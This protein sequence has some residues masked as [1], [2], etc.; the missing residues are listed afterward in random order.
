MAP[1][2]AVRVGEKRPRPSP[3]DVSTDRTIASCVQRLEGAGLMVSGV[4]HSGGAGIVLKGG[5]G[6]ENEVFK[7]CVTP[8]AGRDELRVIQSHPELADCPSLVAPE[9][10]AGMD[11]CFRMRRWCMCL[12]ELLIKR[13]LAVNEVR[14]IVKA[15]GTALAFMHDHGLAHRDVKALNVL[16]DLKD[17]VVQQAGLCDLG[18]ALSIGHQVEEK[19]RGVGTTLCSRGPEEVWPICGEI[20]SGTDIFSFALLIC[21]MVRGRPLV[22]PSDNVSFRMHQ[23][24][25]ELRMMLK[26]QCS[27]QALNSMA[28]RLFREGNTPPPVALLSDLT[29]APNMPGLWDRMRA[30]NVWGS[31]LPEFLRSSTCVMSGMRCMGSMRVFVASALK[32]LQLLEFGGPTMQAPLPEQGPSWE[33]VARAVFKAWGDSVPREVL[34]FLAVA[35]CPAP[36][37]SPFH[38]TWLVPGGM[39]SKHTLGFRRAAR[40]MLQGAEWVPTLKEA[41][42]NAR[43][44]FACQRHWRDLKMGAFHTGVMGC[45]CNL[46]LKGSRFTTVPP[47]STDTASK[48]LFEFPTMLQGSNPNAMQAT[49]TPSGG[50]MG[51]RLGSTLIGRKGST[52]FSVGV[53]PH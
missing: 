20:D 40:A 7:V 47:L 49:G 43:D 33:A 26:G 46:N 3:V 4:L 38:R 6:F 12:Q 39:V 53:A 52:S 41:I 14:V 45:P 22:P 1:H 18:S 8:S 16:V 5:S 10:I 2:T 21:E 34:W 9:P 48:R 28:D 27:G 29:S 24:A 31:D 51:L 36:R 11:G 35:Y 13:R 23:E 32:Q 50:W 25:K 17:G 15:V 19:T 44:S 42:Q 37:K 30:A